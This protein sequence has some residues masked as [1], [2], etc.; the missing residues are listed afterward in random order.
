MVNA[1]V[2]AYTDTST[3][4]AGL[5]I[6]SACFHWKA[7]EAERF[8]GPFNSTEIAGDVLIVGNTADVS[9]GLLTRVRHGNH[10]E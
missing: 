8:V 1:A 2:A 3:L 9:G 4:F 7:R 6:S 10:S 5:G